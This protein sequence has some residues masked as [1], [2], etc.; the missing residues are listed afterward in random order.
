[1]Q[2]HKAS[3]TSHTHTIAKEKTIKNI[4]PYCELRAT[5]KDVSS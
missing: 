2:D 3:K 4:H 1:M 5:R